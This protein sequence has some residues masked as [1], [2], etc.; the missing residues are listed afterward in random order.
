MIFLA[1][2]GWL[3]WCFMRLAMNVWRD[4]IAL[5]TLSPKSVPSGTMPV[6]TCCSCTCCSE[7]FLSLAKGC[8]STGVFPG[9][10]SLFAV[11]FLLQI[12]TG[13][14][15]K[16]VAPLDPTW[17]YYRYYVSPKRMRLLVA[18]SYFLISSFVKWSLLCFGNISG[19]NLI[20]KLFILAANVLNLCLK[21]VFLL[22]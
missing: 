12:L 5:M 3:R 1:L 17:D 13:I 14:E 22:S 11:E 10:I 15:R 6:L 7:Q 16:Y 21:T 20:W 18:W 2:S 4:A 9:H 19:F 8:F